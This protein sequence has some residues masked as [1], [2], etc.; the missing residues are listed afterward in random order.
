MALDYYRPNISGLTLYVETLAAALAGRGHS[1]TV[2]TLAHKSGLPAEETDRGVRIVRAPVIA[3]LGKA[4]VSPAILA[5]ARKELRGCDVLHLHSPLVNAVP[6]ALL[7]RSVKVPIVVTYHCDLRSPPGVIQRTIEALARFSQDF[8]LDRAERIVTYT[9]DYARNTPSLAKRLEQVRWILP[10]VTPPRGTDRTA[11]EIRAQY[12][13]RGDPVLLFLGR[14][15]EEKGLPY[16]VAALP[17][18]RR[19]FPQAALVLAGEKDVPGE[20]VGERLAPLLADPE[21]GVVATGSVAPERIGD[22]FRIADLLVLPS[23]NSTESFG[24]VQIEAMLE[25]VP[26]VASDLPG[27]R[28][29]VTMTGMGEIAPIGDSEGLA[30]QIVRVLESPASHRRSR[31][32]ILSMFSM[33]RTLSEYEDVYREAAGKVH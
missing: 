20:T 18:V 26:V 1:V 23:T 4:L 15:A 21:S 16:L 8:A 5:V 32:E 9:E 11:D 33:K 19:R 6:F 29:P 22:L 25:G 2:L 17:E 13:V 10:P 31:E 14:F 30:R 28:Q 27:V 3:K 24:L 7:A 12:G